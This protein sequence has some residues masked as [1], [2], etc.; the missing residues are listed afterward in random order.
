MK[1]FTLTPGGLL[2][3]YHLGALNALTELGAIQ[4]SIDV[5]GGSSAGAIATMSYGCGLKPTEIL[6]ATISVSDH[7][8]SL[9]RT[10]GNLLPLLEQ[11]MEKRVSEEEFRFLKEERRIGV[12]YREIF[13]RQKSYL[14]TEFQSRED[15]FRAVSWSC[16]FP[17]FSTN[18]PCKVDTSSDSFLPRLMVDGFFSVPRDRL[19]CPIFEGVD[20][21]VAISVFPKSTVGLEAFDE[22]DCIS[23]SSEDG[24]PMTDLIRLATQASSREELTKV[25]ESGYQDA[26]AWFSREKVQEEEED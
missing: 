12:G 2:L 13:P 4:P 26:A 16:M 18:W 15:L 10:R 7:C 11:E 22:N 19:G 20:R 25:Y 23:P 6:E 3:P 17:F 9:G 8:R 21:T 24:L 5:V 14:Q 1:A